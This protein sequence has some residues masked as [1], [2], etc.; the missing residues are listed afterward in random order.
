MTIYASATPI[1]TA[2]PVIEPR[3]PMES[4]NGMAST[5]I[6]TAISGYES[7]CHSATLRRLVSNPLC[8]KS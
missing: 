7:L 1:A 5:A 6:T 2:T 8:C 3:R 4:A